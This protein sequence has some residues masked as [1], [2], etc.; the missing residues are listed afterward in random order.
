LNN[1]FIAVGYKKD[2]NWNITGIVIGK[3]SDGIN[4]DTPVV[5]NTSNTN[6]TG[7]AYNGTNYIISGTNTSTNK[8]VIYKS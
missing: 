1:Q 3:S 8:G 4:W 7:I 5:L 6:I 2:S